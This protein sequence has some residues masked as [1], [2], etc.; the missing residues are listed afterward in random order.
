[1]IR[2]FVEQPAQRLIEFRKSESTG[3]TIREYLDEWKRLLGKTE[4]KPAK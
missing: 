2:T 3:M 4:A 1:M